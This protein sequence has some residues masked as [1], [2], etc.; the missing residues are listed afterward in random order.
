MRQQLKEPRACS[1]S[2][3][4][5]RDKYEVQG[6]FAPAGCRPPAAPRTPVMV[7]DVEN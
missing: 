2:Q 7:E 4:I 1:T 5:T 3:R 6:G